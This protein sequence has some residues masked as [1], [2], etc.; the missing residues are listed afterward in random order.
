MK[1]SAEVVIVGGGPAGS[2]LGTYLSQAGVDNLILEK[3]VHPRPHV[4]ESLV[5]STTR[6]FREI[7]FLDTMEEAGFVHKYGAAWHSNLPGRE[8]SLWFREFPQRGVEQDYTYHVDRAKFDR[9]LFEH[10]RAAGSEVAEGAAVREVLFDGGR[11]SGVRCSVQGRPQEISCR[12][13]VDASGRSSLLGHQLK[14]RRHDPLF[15]QFAVHAWFDGVRRGHGETADFIHIYFLPVRRGWAWQIPI[16]EKITSV[17]VVAEKEV[18]RE[19]KGRLE[20]WFAELAARNPDLQRA[21]AAAV[22]VSEFRS[23]ADY[24]YCMD[25]FAGDGFL[26]VGD[27]AR[28]VDPIFSSGVS[29]ACT[30]AKFAAEAIVQALGGGNGA[31]SALE[32]YERTLRSGVEV[33]YEFIRVYYKLMHLFTHFVEHPDYRLQ[34]LELLQGEVYQRENVPVLDEMRQLI[35][36]VETTEGHVWKPFLGDIPLD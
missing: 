4:G 34:I 31:D 30:G 9:L 16:T 32:G 27:A 5:P 24:S 20:E 10:A 35:H 19:S 1:T 36:T 2:V 13:V 28:F 26:L 8:F 12:F 6:V 15:N 7:G 29:V 3:A 22:P 18:F 33:W 23:E 11:A 17:G 14:L 25:R 21:M